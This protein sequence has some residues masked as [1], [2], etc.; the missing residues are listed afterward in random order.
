MLSRWC[1][2][3]AAL[4]MI[5]KTC[6]V[7]GGLRPVN[8]SFERILRRPHPRDN[9][10]RGPVHKPP[11]TRIK[12]GNQGTFQQAM[13]YFFYVTPLGYGQPLVDHPALQKVL[14]RTDAPFFKIPPNSWWGGRR[15]RRVITDCKKR[16]QTMENRKRRP[17]TEFCGKKPWGGTA[18][19]QERPAH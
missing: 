4:D 5:C 2:S 8:P 7:P 12:M 14:W 19:W 6:Q 18:Y 3:L 17:L 13:L 11:A 15:G 1:H 10:H 9:H 16:G